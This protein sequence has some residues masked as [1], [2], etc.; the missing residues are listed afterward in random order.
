MSRKSVTMEDDRC[1]AMLRDMTGTS[2]RL[3][4]VLATWLDF[5]IVVIGGAISCIFDNTN[6]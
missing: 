6:L 4:C 5:R 2:E 3:T 1:A